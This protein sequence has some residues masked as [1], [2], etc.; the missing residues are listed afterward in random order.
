[1]TGA[2]PAGEAIW[3]TVKKIV[4]SEGAGALM[5][6]CV[7]RMLWI[8]P[9][10]AMNF[11]GYELAKNAMQSA[12]E[13]PSANKEP[14]KAIKLEP[15]RAARVDPPS[16]LPASVA[17]EPVSAETEPV[18]HPVVAPPTSSEIIESHAAVQEAVS[19]NASNETSSSPAEDEVLTLPAAPSSGFRS[20]S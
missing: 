1:M 7:P 19:E 3:V 11:A 12:G 16:A 8:A 4:A 17:S 20:L 5:K 9:L 15:E 14:E 6:G 13:D 2:S 18:A 10:G